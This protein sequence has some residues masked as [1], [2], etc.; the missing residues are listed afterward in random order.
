MHAAAARNTEHAAENDDRV[1][2]LR[3]VALSL[4]SCDQ[5][6]RGVGEFEPV[7]RRETVSRSNRAKVAVRES[8]ETFQGLS[9]RVGRCAGSA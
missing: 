3:G 5:F 8:P 9:K 6:V 2:R 7:P 1:E 4:D